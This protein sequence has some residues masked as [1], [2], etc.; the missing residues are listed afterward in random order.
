VK[1]D[2]LSRGYGRKTRG[3]QLVDPAGSAQEFG[4]EPLLIARKLQVPVVV[5][6]DRFEA[7]RFAEERFGPK[8]TCWTMAFSTEP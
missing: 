8:C 4:D 7:G 6:E 3:V 2:A 5:G 1:F